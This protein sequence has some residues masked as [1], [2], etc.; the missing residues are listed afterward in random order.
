MTN[1]TTDDLA[2]D[3]EKD[4]AYVNAY[5]MVNIACVDPWSAAIRRALAAEAE[6]ARLQAIIDGAQPPPS[7][8]ETELATYRH[9][10]ADMLAA[11]KE[12]QWVLIHGVDILGYYPD[13][14]AAIRAGYDRVGLN[15]PFMV[16]QVAATDPPPVRVTRPVVRVRTAGEQGDSNP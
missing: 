1:P 5:G 4:L 3:L 16:R 9:C 7:A 13:Q 12:D 10:R 8:L 6:V 15:T 2:R 14:D 11:G